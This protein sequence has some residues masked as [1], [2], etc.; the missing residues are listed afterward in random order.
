MGR[1]KNYLVVTGAVLA[2]ATACTSALVTDAQP[3]TAAST[4]APTTSA[5]ADPV[6]NPAEYY[7]KNPNAVPPALQDAGVVL[8]RQLTG[9]SVITNLD[10]S[11]L[12]S[13]TVIVSCDRDTRY[14]E[15]LGTAD[16]PQAVAFGGTSCGGENLSSFGVPVKEKGPFT[17]LETQ[18]EPGVRYY[19]TIYDR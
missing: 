8:N 19:V 5:A 13:V 1:A 18:V 17:Q 2:A 7:A 14:D 9:Y 10:F 4:S 15:H 3:S 16:E 12:T 6:F 11:G